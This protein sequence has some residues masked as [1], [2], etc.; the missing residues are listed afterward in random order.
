MSEGQYIR[1]VY[2]DSQHQWW[3]NHH[4]QYHATN[5]DIASPEVLVNPLQAMLCW[6]ASYG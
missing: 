2:C 3:D 6:L 1:E 5:V 4:Q